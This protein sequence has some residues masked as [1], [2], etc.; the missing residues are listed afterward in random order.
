MTA[1]WGFQTYFSSRYPGFIWATQLS[2]RPLP[3]QQVCHRHCTLCLCH[4]LSQEE[5]QRRYLQKPCHQYHEDP[6]YVCKTEERGEQDIKTI[7]NTYQIAFVSLVP[8]QNAKLSCI[9]FGPNVLYHLKPKKYDFISCSN[10]W[11]LIE[12]F[13]MKLLKYRRKR[14]I[15]IV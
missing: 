13:N 7:I 2:R 1:F 5:S 3:L 11:V 4:C 8:A 15:D 6:H 14:L 10:P 12:K 9:S